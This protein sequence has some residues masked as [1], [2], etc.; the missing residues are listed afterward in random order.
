MD[1]Y[2]LRRSEEL[3]L[4]RMPKNESIMD[5]IFA[6]NVRNLEATSSIKLS[7]YIIGL[8][9]FLIYFGSQVNKTRVELMEKRNVLDLFIDKSIVKGRTKG[10]KRRKVIDSSP[11]L[12]QMEYDINLL[13]QEVALVEN[14]EKY[15]MELCN[16]FK[17]ELTRRENELRFIRE[18]RKL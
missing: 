16:S 5:E 8:S 18:E 12:E 13:E 3:M 11:D 6:F 9:Q 7:Q 2:L 4:D 1:N 10:D 15:L 14:R 17:R